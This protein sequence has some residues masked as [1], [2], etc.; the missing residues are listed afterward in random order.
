MVVG[1]LR[2]HCGGVDT[3]AEAPMRRPTARENEGLNQHCD[4]EDIKA[5]LN[6]IR[7]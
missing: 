6:K 7:G 3:G 2:A 1:A 4:S 5:R